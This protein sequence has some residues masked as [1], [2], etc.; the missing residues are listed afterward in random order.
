MHNK[1]GVKAT[2]CHG[3]RAKATSPQPMPS[4]SPAEGARNCRSFRR[5]R[6][7]AVGHKLLAKKSSQKRSSFL[8]G[9]AKSSNSLQRTRYLLYLI[10]LRRIT[11][12]A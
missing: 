11:I 12:I 8:E 4:A 1:T 9:A 10:T 2:A 3:W 7:A 5:L 6:M